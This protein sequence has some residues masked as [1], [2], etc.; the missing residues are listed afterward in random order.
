[1]LPTL[2]LPELLKNDNCN[3]YPFKK[4]DEQQNT[5]ASLNFLL[6]FHPNPVQPSSP[7][8]ISRSFG[9]GTEL[10]SWCT[11]ECLWQRLG[12]KEQIVSK[13]ELPMCNSALEKGSASGEAQGLMKEGQAVYPF[14]IYGK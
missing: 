14:K 9:H 13:L 11:L 12:K 8:L 10:Y 3:A 5:A 4:S 2:Y 1:M 6:L 7:T